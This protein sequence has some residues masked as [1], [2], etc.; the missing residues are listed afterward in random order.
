MDFSGSVVDTTAGR[1]KLLVGE[2]LAA[3]DSGDERGWISFRAWD[4]RR[5]DAGASQRSSELGE[6]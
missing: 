5:T 2:P 1:A 6:L 4:T 3:P